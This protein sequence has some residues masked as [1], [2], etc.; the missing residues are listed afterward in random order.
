[1]PIQTCELGTSDTTCGSGSVICQNCTFTFPSSH[2]VNQ[3][4]NVPP[5]CLCTTG[6]CDSLGRCQPGASN[7]MCGPPGNTCQDCTQTAST[8]CEAQQ[9]TFVT[10]VDAGA[11]NE[12][13]CPSGCC[14]S[15]GVCQQGVTSLNCGGFGTNCQ[16]CLQT[17]TV[18]S[19]QQCTTPPDA[20]TVCNPANCNG[21]C[22]P[23]G[24]CLG[25]YDEA[26]CGF[27]GRRCLD[28]S[29]LG[30][31]CEFGSCT[32]PDGSTPC[33]QSCA[34][35]C[36]VGGN[37]QNGYANTQC[38]E[39]GNRCQDCTSLT[40]ASTCD[41]VV[42]PR[43]CVSQQT[44]CPAPYTSCPAPLQ[45]QAPARQKVCS[46]LD[47]Q[48]AAGACAGGAYSTAC[49]A[50][51]QQ[52]ALNAG[53]GLC[54]E[55]FDWDFVEQVGTRTCVA[56]FLSATCNHNSA[57]IAD[58]VQESCYNCPDQSSTSQCEAQAPSGTCSS[59]SQADQCVATALA[60]PGAVCNPAAYQGN[61]G[62]W[63]QAVG[64][65]YCGM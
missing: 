57:C 63:L 36:D 26:Q 31:Q 30:A 15:A 2:C 55:A 32:T 62:A 12:Q 14:D 53:C 18:C 35:C 34:G 20:G 17:N 8:L 11:C 58:C 56:P 45:Q 7:T 59:F 19:T 33:S 41:V 27:G 5:P 51:L 28:C 6:C 4:C 47:L 46:A 24:N 44:Q 42:S 40:P 10:D 13:S 39:L 37:C 43:T 64:A 52:S 49:T 50:F 21:C 25:G 60:G 65:L 38:G 61:F 23:Q 29:T 54:L 1:M 3:Q 48:N 9:C 16:N 22:D